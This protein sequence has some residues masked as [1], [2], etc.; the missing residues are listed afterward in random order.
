MKNTSDITTFYRL[1]SNKAK[2]LVKRK[3]DISTNEPS[4]L[5]KLPKNSI[6]CGKPGN[7][8]HYFPTIHFNISLFVSHLQTT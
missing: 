2:N 5:S 8:A 3:S 6:P 1:E 7:V 4:T